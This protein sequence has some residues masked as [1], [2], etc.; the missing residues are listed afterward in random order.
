MSH[1]RSRRLV[2]ENVGVARKRPSR[3]WK[4]ELISINN[5]MI[6]Q[7][8]SN[9]AADVSKPVSTSTQN[10]FDVISIVPALFMS[11]ACEYTLFTM[12]VSSYAC[13]PA[14]SRSS[15]GREPGVSTELLIARF[16][17]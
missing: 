15:P 4:S 9:A 13:S 3:V 10:R 5:D 8:R 11:R 7:P 14:R 1:S 2:P 6:A 17:R 16:T 12:R